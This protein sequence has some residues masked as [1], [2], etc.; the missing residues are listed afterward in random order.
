MKY[1]TCPKEYRRKAHGCGTGT[2]NG[3]QAFLDLGMKCPKCGAELKTLN[4]KKTA[5]KEH[6]ATEIKQAIEFVKDTFGPVAAS[7]YAQ[8][9]KIS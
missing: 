2:Y 6:E 8:T 4:L 3:T 5:R 9:K 7:E 1:F